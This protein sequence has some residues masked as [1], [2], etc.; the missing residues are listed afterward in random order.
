MTNLPSGWLRASLQDLGVQVQPGFASGKHNRDGN[1]LLHL[2]PMNITRDGRLDTSDARFV[3]DESDRRVVAGDVLF[4]NTNSPALVGKTTI[5]SSPSPL[6]YSNHMTRLR[7][8]DGLDSRFLAY[9]LHWLWMEGYFRSVLSHHVNQASVSSKVLL[10]TNIAVPPLPEQCRIVAAIEDH[11]S[12]LDAGRSY[13][14]SAERQASAFVT[15]LRTAAVEGRLIETPSCREDIES[16]FESERRL[17]WHGEC[18]NRRYKE[19][20]DPDLGLVPIVPPGWALL[21][22]EAATDPVRVI[23]YGILMPKVKEDGTVPY[24]EVKDLAGETLDGK[25]LHKT[26]R[27]LDEKFAGSR[28]AFGDVV[29]AV[30]G[31]Y[32]RSAIVPAQLA[33]A[34]VSRDV[35]RIAPLSG[36]RPE[37]LQCYLQS[38]FV[39]K[40]LR[41]HARGVAVK[42]VNTAAIRSLPIAVPPLS[43]QESII[44]TVAQQLSTVEQVDNEIGRSKI[45]VD[46]LRRSLLAEAFVGRLVPQDSDDEPASVLLERIRAERA[47]AV[48]AARRHGSH[49]GSKTAAAMSGS[50]TESRNT[51]EQETVA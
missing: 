1:G 50:R 47:T 14:L 23:R 15:A 20:V 44:E 38:S 34:N 28:L 9:Q 46:K 29:L 16:H 25:L 42:G 3:E 7:P 18:G 35:V 43:I 21:S 51:R 45:H 39:K 22:L 13:L 41:R 10:Q 33:G 8:P 4:N 32:E 17:R 26:S 27:E 6:G 24:V 12:R 11:L 2:R 49:T 5:I 36:L 40:Y 48:G 19:P 30:R 31:S 37:Y